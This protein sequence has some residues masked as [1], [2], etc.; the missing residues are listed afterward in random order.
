MYSKPD[1]TNANDR[2]AHMLSEWHN[3]SA[4]LGWE[5]YRPL[6]SYLMSKFA[7]RDN[8]MDERF[9][10]YYTSQ[11]QLRMLCRRRA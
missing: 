2:L 7:I 4:P 5:R 10:G 6:A 11:T 8:V 1:M 3:D 9:S